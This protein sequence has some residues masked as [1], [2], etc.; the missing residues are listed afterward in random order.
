MVMHIFGDSFFENWMHQDNEPRPPAWQEQLATRLGCA[1]KYHGLAGSSVDYT[2]KKFYEVLPSIKN[3][4]YVII[5]ITNHARIYSPIQEKDGCAAALLMSDKD[6]STMYGPNWKNAVEIGL[7]W[8]MDEDLNKCHIVS[9]LHGVSTLL[10]HIHDKPLIIE[11]FGHD[12]IDQSLLAGTALTYAKGDLYTP[13]RNEFKTEADVQR[14]QNIPGDD[15]SNHLSPENHVILAN[16]L[17]AY[18]T[19]NKPVDLTSGFVS[20]IYNF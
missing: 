20:K 9:F 15:R 18:F 7:K 10:R 5:G 13:C 6:A 4:D 11:C 8:F 19:A 14:H 12:P 17:F 3:D 2:I 16:K 1:V